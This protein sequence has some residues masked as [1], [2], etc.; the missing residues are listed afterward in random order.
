MK[1]LL[2]A[3]L[4]VAAMGAQA[5]VTGTLVSPDGKAVAGA[6]VT[7]S[8]AAPFIDR[9]QRFV[10]GKDEPRI[11]TAESDSKGN[12]KLPVDTR[13]NYVV[14]ITRTGFAPVF[15]Q[16]TGDQDVGG[17]LLRPAAIKSGRVTANGKA[18]AGARLYFFDGLSGI[19]IETDERG[20]YAVPDPAMWQPSVHA[21]H[22]GY[23]LYQ[24]NAG[25]SG[26]L[27]LD[28]ALREGVVLRGKVLDATGRTGAKAELF[29]DGVAAG[30]T[31]DDGSFDLR[32][33]AAQWQQLKAVAGSALAQGGR[34]NVS[35]LRLAKPVTLR[36]SVFD[37]KTRLPLAGALVTLTTDPTF[38]AIGPTTISDAKGQ[39][40]LQTLPGS[41]SIRVEHAG[42]S[43]F[44]KT[45]FNV[46]ATSPLLRAHLQRNARFIGRITS[47]D[48]RQPVAGARP[49]PMATSRNA[50][51][52]DR[53]PF[54][55]AI[56]GRYSVDVPQWILNF[57]DVE[58]EVTKRGYALAKDGPHTLTAGEE[59]RVDILLSRGKT[60]KGR[61]VDTNGAPV[62]RVTVAAVELVGR[63]NAQPWYV[64]WTEEPTT[65]AEGEFTLQLRPG[66]Y[67]VF[68]HHPGYAPK[69]V[70][71]IDLTGV[72]TD[73]EVK[74]DQA[75][76]ISGRVVTAR[77]EPVADLRVGVSVDGPEV[78]TRTAVDGTFL[79]AG[80][81]SGKFSISIVSDDGSVEEDRM[82]KAPSENVTIELTPTVRVS[83]RVTTKEGDPVTDFTTST[84]PP[85]NNNSWHAP[86][87]PQAFHDPEGR[88]VLER[89]PVRPT[90][91]AVRA[92]GFAQARVALQLENEKNVTGV[93]VKLERAG[94]VTGRV[95]D[96]SGAPIAGARALIPSTGSY[97][98]TMSA[99]TDADGEYT[100]DAVPLG[101]TTLEFMKHG[102]LP[103]KRLVTIEPRETRIDIRLET[104]KILTGRVVT[105]TGA[106]VSEAQVYAQTAST[107]GR[108]TNAMTDA[109]G[110]FRLEGLGSGIYALRA[111]KRGLLDAILETVDVDTAGDLTLTLRAGATVTGRILGIDVSNVQARALRVGIAGSGYQ[112]NGSID[113]NGTYRV[114]GAPLGKVGVRAFVQGRTS[115]LAEIETSN[116]GVYTVDLEFKD[117][118]T[119]R[120]RVTR[121]GAP[122][123]GG[124][125]AF[126]ARGGVRFGTTS[127]IGDDGTYEIKGVPNGD[128]NI[129]VANI[130]VGADYV[131]TRTI[132]QSQTIDINMRPASVAVR[133]VDD[134][135]G[136]PIPN[137][138]LSLHPHDTA[139]G[140]NRPEG[141]TGADGRVVLEN[142]SP[143]GYDVRVTREGF[144]AHLAGRTLTE[145]SIDEFEVRLTRSEGFRLT[146]I[147]ARTGQPV[148]GAI[149]VRT[150]SG[151]I[152]YNDYY[153]D[154]R[155]DGSLLLPLA[156]GSYRINVFSPGLGN[157]YVT[158]TSPG[159]QQVTLRPGGTLEFETSG[160]V[161]VR[162][163]SSDGAIYHMAP[164]E[165]APFHVVLDGVRY[166]DV[167]PGAYIV[168]VVDPNGSVTK[169][170]RVE[171][172]EGQITKVRL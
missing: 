148:T 50:F 65:D 97:G 4:G 18:V 10:D 159:A 145:G 39:F 82:M 117:H 141:I 21:V 29:V 64:R 124:H 56:D 19:T 104:G 147:D 114:D 66:R 152:V 143:G 102:Y 3:V 53:L 47:S 95:T 121:N 154:S 92:P 34:G 26:T 49:R 93:E 79:L 73:L 8:A 151:A 78:S 96:A 99:A 133:V 35:T 168:E 153:G 76:A 158:A 51:Y 118:N 40:S 25:L 75:V 84:A 83:G 41:Y 107:G 146:L 54:V 162:L 42:Y 48:D 87:T 60:L 63:A 140:T 38:Q 119:V 170:E 7:L 68:F 156:P 106:P 161:P 45:Q 90:E 126:R 11:V 110:R 88:F 14:S 89:V 167:A 163:R 16:A 91:L 81:P 57:G 164:N 157:A 120:G 80:L 85:E 43:Q 155:P 136:D 52:F 125:I 109:S 108:G 134:V 127:A 144:A 137:A 113:P 30:A 2:V 9:L 55:S 123:R 128:Y 160:A 62:P 130:T 20:N 139:Q 101:E 61:V 70:S 142:L 31:A 13:G 169:S 46:L 100:L 98:I 171:I 72:P 27:R 129:T 122:L 36:G 135:S 15:V 105:E 12:F 6:Q 37:A 5:D 69:R 150:P 74:L 111:S 131:I 17:V 44:L 132:T 33:V 116:G 71:S 94:S 165:T 138:G 22:G 166:T 77:G 172:R 67:D 24:D 23:A 58:V 32:H 103:V 86:G 59:K 112:A 149:T 28:I 1:R 115:E